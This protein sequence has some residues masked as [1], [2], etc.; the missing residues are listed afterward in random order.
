MNTE[1]KKTSRVWNFISSVRVFISNTFFLIITILIV[2]SILFSIFSDSTKDPSN[3][4]LFF[5]PNGPIVEQITGNANPF[6]ELFADNQS[7][8]LSSRKALDVLTAVKDDP[9]IGYIVLKLDNIQGTG[10]TVLFD[11]G[12]ALKKAKDSGKK[13]LAIGDSYSQSAYYLASYADEVIVNPDGV[14]LIEGYSRYRNYYKSFLDKLKISINLFKVGSYK[15]AMEPFIRDT[16]SAED[17][18]AS[19][20]WMGDLWSSWKEDVSINRGLEPAD[21]Q[22]YADNANIL[23][24]DQFGD[25]AKAA[26]KA[27]LI[28]K[29]LNR[30]QIREYLE[31]L[32]GSNSEQGNESFDNIS[33]NEYWQVIESEK[34]KPNLKN[35]AVIVAKGEIVYGNQ[36]PG[37]IGGD[38]TARL[39]RDA[40]NNKDVKA[41]VLRIDSGGGSAFASEVIR[42]EIIEAKKQNIPVI[43]S[44]SN[45]AASGGYWIAASADEIWASHDTITG[46]IGIFGAF[47]TFEKSLDHIGIHSDGIGTSE[48][49]GS[50]NLSRSINPKISEIFQSSVE[51][52]YKRFITLVAEER[53]LST[54][55]VEKIAQGRVW[56]GNQALNIGLVDNL[57]N[58]SDAISKAANLAELIEYQPFFP[59]ESSDWKELLLEGLLSKSI[60][61]IL[62]M[63]DLDLMIEQPSLIIKDFKKFKDPRGIYAICSDCLTY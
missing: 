35:I 2:L 11:L 24:K 51:Y 43:A 13:I 9:R 10:Q 6:S 21:I 3:K 47:P 27:N 29:I 22:F 26:K 32:V 62:S 18:E 1:I 37:Q 30:T 25:M 36:P 63:L 34:D 5:S 16:M 39:I 12:Q 58:L 4:A 7:I 59:E 57:G 41:I 61:S 49:A 17:K 23:I 14:V 40:R 28:D 44:M 20:F 33:I 48:L 31:E 38:S 52:G 53:N 42:E 50:Q 46:S 60:K 19:M 8:E 15:S 55:E 54:E 45:V 56:S